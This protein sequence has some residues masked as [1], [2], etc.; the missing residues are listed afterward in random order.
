MN[1]SD[2]KTVFPSVWTSPLPILNQSGTSIQEFQQILS[3]TKEQSPT[4]KQ[5][6]ESGEKK[7]IQILNKEQNKRGIKFKVIFGTEQPCYRSATELK[8]MGYADEIQFFEQQLIA[9]DSH[10]QVSKNVEEGAS[11]IGNESE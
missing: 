4:K 5:K 3:K 8:K 1:L 7:P 10:K 9:S 6:K 11:E 2:M